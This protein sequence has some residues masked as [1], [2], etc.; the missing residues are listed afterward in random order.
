MNIFQDSNGDYSSKRT[1]G[2]IYML[3]A[4]LLAAIDQVTNYE[5]NSF[6][7][8]I[9]IVIT[10]GSLLGI[11]LFEGKLKGKSSNASMTVDPDRETPKTRG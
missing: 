1:L 6:E 2:I 7:V 4:L 8:W 11:T 9:A 10:G 3:A 5:I